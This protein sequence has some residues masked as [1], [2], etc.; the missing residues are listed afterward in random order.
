MSTKYLHPAPFLS[1]LIDKPIVVRLKWGMEYVG[2]LVSFDTRMNIHIRNGQ[3]FIR[4]E[5]QAEIGDILIRCNNIM[6]IREKPDEYPLAPVPQDAVVDED[7][8][9]GD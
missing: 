2:V 6:H 4:G 5:L 7:D 1:S 3:E 8:E 9:V